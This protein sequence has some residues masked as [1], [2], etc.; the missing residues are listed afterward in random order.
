[1]DGQTCMESLL[2]IQS[3]VKV[4]LTVWIFLIWLLPAWVISH[5]LPNQPFLERLVEKT[6]NLAGNFLCNGVQC[7]QDEHNT[8]TFS[9]YSSEIPLLSFEEQSEGGD[10]YMLESTKL[11]K[12]FTLPSLPQSWRPHPHFDPNTHPILDTGYL[13]RKQMLYKLKKIKNW[14]IQIW[15]ID[16]KLNIRSPVLERNGRGTQHKAQNKQTV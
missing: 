9:N 3:G 6:I 1:M 2:H 4:F 12:Y 11:S 13:F 5:S 10:R 14:I 16:C 15:W 8:P 7:K